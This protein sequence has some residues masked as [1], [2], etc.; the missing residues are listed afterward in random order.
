MRTLTAA[1]FHEVDTTFR[2]LLLSLYPELPTRAQLAA[3]ADVTAEVLDAY[4]SGDYEIDAV[5]DP[6]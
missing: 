3:E 5:V 4:W 2:N 1:E 6:T